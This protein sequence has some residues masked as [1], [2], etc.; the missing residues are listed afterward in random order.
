MRVW[1]GDSAL[2]LQGAEKIPIALSLQKKMS[3][4]FAILGSQTNPFDSWQSDTKS[5]TE[6]PTRCFR[7]LLGGTLILLSPLTG[8]ARPVTSTVY[9]P[10]F[11]G[12]TTYCG[13][14]YQHWGISAAHP[15]L[16]CGTRV[17]VSHRGRSLTV[18]IT[19]RCDYNSIDL[20]AGTAYRLGVPLDGIATV[21]ISY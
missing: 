13:E 11:H 14:R 9:A 2:Y 3:N 12:G 4:F 10:E 16:P 17:R 19:D 1:L 7:A 18:P 6:L 5:R 21:Q 8:L 20:S 15:W